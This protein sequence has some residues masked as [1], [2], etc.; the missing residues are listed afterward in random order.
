MNPSHS[1]PSATSTHPVPR[2]PGA[3]AVRRL[4]LLVGAGAELPAGGYDAVVGLGGAEPLGARLRVSLKV[5][6]GLRAL[7]DFGALCVVL[8]PNATRDDVCGR[9][10]AAKALYSEL[11]GLAE[12]D[13][14]FEARLL[15]PSSVR[16][17]PSATA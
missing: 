3:S 6:S 1:L 17:S 10:P 4:L 14:G 13:G 7:A 9:I 12:A 11:R 16:S 8:F 2:P 15:P 5:G